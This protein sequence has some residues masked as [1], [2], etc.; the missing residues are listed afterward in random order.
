MRGDDALPRHKPR[1]RGERLVDARRAEHAVE[2]SGDRP[3]GLDLRTQRGEPVRLDRGGR[4]GGRG[5][6][7]GQRPLLQGGGV[8]DDRFEG[9]GPHRLEPCAEHRLDR[10]LPSR[11]DPHHLREPGR[12]GKTPGFEPFDHRPGAGAESLLLQRRERRGAGT[13][14]PEGFTRIVQRLRCGMDGFAQLLDR[15]LC[16]GLLL[17][18]RFQRPLHCFE[19]A[20]D[21]R[22]LALQGFGIDRVALG[23]ERARPRVELLDARF[24]MPD[25]GLL[26]IHRP[27]RLAPALAPR[28]ELRLEGEHFI[29]DFA[30]RAAGVR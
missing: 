19:P 28:L 20:S 21:R 8:R 7:G 23:F 30:E 25:A 10:V 29:L 12:T 6:D 16:P 15:R 14:L 26:R 22:R 17:F 3:L 13:K 1:T 24:E 5:V 11:R 9:V 27:G 2:Q 18:G 4:F